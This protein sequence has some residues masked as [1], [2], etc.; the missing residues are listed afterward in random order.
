MMLSS[1]LIGI[2]IKNFIKHELYVP[3]TQGFRRNL[4]FPIF[5]FSIDIFRLNS[6]NNL[7][8]NTQH[9]ISKKQYLFTQ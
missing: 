2:D 9:I 4:N 3:N 1:Y 6:H 7:L 5:L 8:Q